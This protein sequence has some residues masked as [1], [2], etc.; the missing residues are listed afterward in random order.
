VAINQDGTLN[1]PENP[2][3]RGSIVA[4][5]GT[6]YGQTDPPCP[7]GGVNLPDAVPLSPGINAQIDYV[8]PALSGMQLAPVEYAGSAPTLI[9]GIVQINFQVPVNVAPGSFSFS[10]AIGENG[11]IQALTSATIAVK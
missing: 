2:A 5:W 3:P 1:G 6:G 11:T 7:I 9:C 10:P 8:D 4:V